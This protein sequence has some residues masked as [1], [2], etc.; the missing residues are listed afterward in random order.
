M[1]NAVLLALLIA[2]LAGNLFVVRR[3][4]RPQN[5]LY[6]YSTSSRAAGLI[7]F[8]ASFV[9]RWMPGS[10]CTVWFLLAVERGLYAQYIT[11]YTIGAVLMLRVCG[12]PLWRIGAKHRLETQADFIELRYGSPVFKAFFSFVTFIVWFPWVILELKTIG[13]AITATSNYSIEYN[14]SIITVT[15]FIIITCF[16]GGVRGVNNGSA[17]QTAVFTAFLCACAYLL[18][19]ATFGGLFTMCA[20][21]AAE[22]PEALVLDFSAPHRFELASA[23]L[24]GM[25]GSMFWPGMFCHIYAAKNEGVIRKACP[26][27]LCLALPVF[28]LTLALGMGARLLPGV[29]LSDALGLFRIAEIYG[30]RLLRAML[31]V[32]VTAACMTM[33]APM[34]SVAGTMIA[35]DMLP[36]LYPSAKP[37]ALKSAKVCTVAVGLVAL[38]LATIEFPNLVSLVMLMYN[39]IIQAAPPILLGLWMRRSNLRGAAAG[40]LAGLFITLIFSMFPHFT[41]R[42]N[43]LSAGMAGFIA[44]MIVHAAVSVLT[45]RRE[46]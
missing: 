26:L 4:H 28:M 43:G 25:L 23:T 45:G 36:L 7:P 8:L 3:G 21:I 31:G 13:Q 41:Y 40:M 11:V 6:E 16:Y 46:Q 2:F 18:I 32:G 39:F 9:G 38:W 17:L 37:D 29:D 44:N 42:M 33:C 35:K 22:A 27:A 15:M 24:S 30:N 14:L 1:N 10:V 20:R 34:F 5:D 12:P 19:R